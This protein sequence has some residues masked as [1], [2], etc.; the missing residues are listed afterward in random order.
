MIRLVSFS[1]AL[2]VALPVH[3]EKRAFTLEDLYRV[4]TVG[5]LDVSPDGAS[6]LYTVTV[7][8]LPHGTRQAHVWM[9]DTDGTQQRQIT[10]G[11][12]LESAPSFSPD[13]KWIAFV[14]TRDGE[15]NLY[16]MPRAGGESRALTKVSTGVSDPVWSADARSIAFASDVYPECGADEACNKKIAERW[17]NGPL[18]AHLAD[19]LFYRHWTTW[20][21][22]TRTHTLIADIESGALRDV[23]PGDA[24]SPDFQVGG[25]V[26]YDFSPDGRELVFMSKRVS[27]PESSTNAD[28]WIQS[29][30]DPNAPPRNVTASN[31]G[32]DGTPRYSP[33]GRY[34]AYRTQR[35]PGYESD[36]FR[37]ALYDRTSGT[38]R[39]LAENFQDWVD[40][41]VWS[42][43]SRTLYFT[44]D[45]RGDTPIFRLDVA[46]GRVDRLPTHGTIDDFALAGADRLIYVGRTVGLPA[47]VYSVRLG[48]DDTVA[49]QPLTAQNA[50]LVQ[51]VDIRP[52]ERMQVPGTLGATLDVSSSSPTGSIRRGGIPS[53]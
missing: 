31:E 27:H 8:D 47:E 40:D 24:D 39:V 1:L 4:R 11:D 20:K 6:V 5:G 9:M 17:R 25:P 3:A 51:E 36:L 10:F 28:L 14:S 42:D 48:D 33:D 12:K 7:P 26:A 37:I 45:V 2:L 49:P 18:T 35:E 52:A 19:A 43:D 15:P 41:F 16:V 13:G 44:A 30:S 46:T 29:L 32:W 38:S 34:I 53:S 23:T 50:A 22:G 21:D